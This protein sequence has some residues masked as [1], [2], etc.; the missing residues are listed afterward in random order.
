MAK[1]IRHPK[2][3]DF[4]LPADRVLNCDYIVRFY[5]ATTSDP[6]NNTT[7]SRV[8]AE[9]S[10]NDSRALVT[11]HSQ[12]RAEPEKIAKDVLDQIMDFLMSDDE[13]LILG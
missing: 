12:V 1:W 5:V 11:V 10:H 8:V 13:Q 4:T 9:M 7:T 6:A 2:N 3:G